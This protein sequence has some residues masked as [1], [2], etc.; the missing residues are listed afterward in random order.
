MILTTKEKI[1][2][3]ALT[4][5]AQKGYEGATMHEIAHAVGINKASIYNHYKG[6][7]D[8]YLA[9]YQDV[10]REYE[11]LLKRLI[12]NSENMEIHDKLLYMFKE[13]ILF[14]YKDLHI[15]LFWTNSLLLTPPEIRQKLYI[16]ILKREEPFEKKMLEILKEG[17][18]L[19][20]IRRDIPSKMLVSYRAMR[21]GLLLWMRIVPELSGEWI[22]VFW[23]DFWLG[24]QGRNDGYDEREDIQDSL[25]FKVGL[26]PQ[27]VGKEAVSLYTTDCLICKKEFGIPFSDYRYKDLKYHRDVH[28]VCDDCGRKVQEECQKITGLTPEMV[29]IWEK[30]MR[31]MK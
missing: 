30:V 2:K 12:K 23:K 19:G 24:I 28:H 31:S 11:R 17:M 15:S 13:Y 14:Y 6:K 5:F 29:D 16:D 3:A 22:E 4:A 8:L 25:N 1:K 21:D 18:Q 9:V 20:I 27:P 26:N 7:E 10:A